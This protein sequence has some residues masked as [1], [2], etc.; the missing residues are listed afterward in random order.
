MGTDQLTLGPDIGT[1][2]MGG[3]DRKSSSW[4]ISN[5]P[6][7]YITLIS[8]QF[9]GAAL[10]L[11]TVM[12][13]TRTAGAETYGAV[14]AILAASQ[15]AQVFVNWS[16][17][18][19]VRFGVDEFVDTGT[20]SRAFWIRFGITTLN[21][22]LVVVIAALWF[23]LL[24]PLLKISPDVLW[25][26]AAH[27]VVT[28][29][30][31]HVQ[32]GMQASKMLR[33][34]GF[35]Q[36]LERVT[37]FVSVA[38]LSL[39]G[40]LAFASVAL[41]YISAPAIMTV[42]GLFT[43][44]KQITKRFGFDWAFVKKLLLYSLPLLP[45]TFIG[46]FS[47]SYIDAIFIARFLSIHDL[48]VYYI[49]TQISGILLQAPTLANT[50]LVPLFITLN[51]EDAGEKMNAYFSRLLPTLTLGWGLIGLFAA[52]AATIAIP[53]FFGSDFYPAVVPAWILLTSS[54]LLIPVFCGYAAVTHARSVTYIAAITATVGA[55]TNIALN[56]LLIPLFGMEGCAW[57]TVASYLT[58]VSVY[59]LLLRTKVGVPLSWLLLAIVPSLTSAILYSWTKSAGWAV[60]ASLGVLCLVILLKYNSIHSSIG[61]AKRL[62]RG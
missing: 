35:L 8:F 59:A 32:N 38:G 36:M 40:K 22:A 58:S 51:K 53:M 2:N 10:S 17:A 54:A 25:L 34:Q 41:S 55:S 12:I 14:V 23:P 57:A 43:L 62:V 33:P 28:V 49:A 9:V 61:I 26:V 15:V 4:D 45:F 44:R 31:V 1:A 20:I 39:S 21:T 60:L 50:L 46:Y 52:V 42:I 29:Y 37:I 16:S 24:A 27:L 30:W 6:R 18:S 3:S 47:G 56:F 5:A 11:L 19:V 7:N 13:V 48:G